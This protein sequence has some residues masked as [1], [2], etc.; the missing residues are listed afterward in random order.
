MLHLMECVHRNRKEQI[1]AS[2]LVSDD[3]VNCV[4]C[5]NELVVCGMEDRTSMVNFVKSNKC[6]ICMRFWSRS[7][8][9]LC[10]CYVIQFKS[11]FTLPPDLMWC[12]RC[13]CAWAVGE[14]GGGCRRAKLAQ[15]QSDI[16]LHIFQCCLLTEVKPKKRMKFAK[17]HI[18][19]TIRLNSTHFSRP[20][21]VVHIYINIVSHSHEDHSMQVVFITNM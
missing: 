19:T 15:V 11:H 10:T 21:N 14:V 16:S 5:P 1:V 6:S 4:M 8:E 7:A 13:G 20:S 3:N 9:I 18:K 17:L 2:L 12:L